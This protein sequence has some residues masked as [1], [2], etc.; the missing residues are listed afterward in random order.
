MRNSIA[1]Q[2]FEYCKQH[3]NGFLITGDAGFGVWE[4]FQ[5]SMPQQYINAGINEQATI[6]FAAGMALSGHKTFIYN[7][8]PFV[9]YRC[10]EQVRNDICYHDLPIVLIGIGSG[11]TYAPAG[12]THYALEDIGLARTMPNLDI[13]SPS[14]PMQAKKAVAYAIESKKPTYIRVSKSGE[15][16]ISSA[17]AE[18]TDLDYLYSDGDYALLFH[19][20][21]SDEVITAYNML[22]TEG[23]KV[24]VVSV[25]HL[26]ADRD[27]FAKLFDKYKK[28][29]V[30]EEH[31]EN[32][33]L[34]T[35]LQEYGFS[36]IKIAIQNHFIH[37]IG[38]TKYLRKEFKID[39]SGIA[40]TLKERI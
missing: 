30:I 24:A 27:M 12:M 23:I 1:S 3:K 31:F 9:L 21:I 6:G 2:I 18:I 22:L 20:S 25:V 16:L 26:T 7:I 34:G 37:K 17:N 4:A 35:I 15:P 13:F 10:Y 14:D 36:P 39:A 28:V 38:N 11:I 8:A 29:F 32:G 19:G 33:G 40:T 5:N